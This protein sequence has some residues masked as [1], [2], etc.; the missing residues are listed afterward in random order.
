MSTQSQAL[1]KGAIFVLSFLFLIAIGLMALWNFDF[2]SEKSISKIW[3]QASGP[4]IL[5]AMFLISM[6]MPFVAMRWRALLREKKKT[7]PVL[8]TGILSAAFVLNLALPGPVGELLS[9]TMLKNRY[10]ISISKGLSGL[11]V[12]RIIGLGSACAIAGTMYWVA[13]LALSDDWDAILQ[14]SAIVLLLGGAC[15]AI[16][17]IFPN[18]FLSKIDSITATGWKEKI[19]RIGK[20]L[21]SALIETANLGKK[22]YLESIFWAFMGH[23]MVASGIYVAAGS[24]GITLSWTAIAFTYAASI[25]ASVAMFMLPGSTVAWDLLFTSTLSLAGGI[26]LVEAG[27]ITLVVRIQQLIVVLVGLLMLFWLSRDLLDVQ[28]EEEQDS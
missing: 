6:S 24:I 5:G 25:A 22:S 9:A 4:S 7:S 26:S 17:G 15:L 14:L 2:G 19:V 12:S 23:L 8:L 18:F 28:V 1:K 10:Q 20:Q 16:L 21:F 11:L 13:P 3:S 27:L